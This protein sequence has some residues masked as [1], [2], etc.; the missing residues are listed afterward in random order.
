VGLGFQQAG[1]LGLMISYFTGQFITLGLVIRAVRGDV[2]WRRLKMPVKRLA[3]VMVRHRRFPI[4]TLPS[5]FISNLTINSPIYAL[6][7]IGAVAEIGL[8][9]RANQLLSMPLTILGGAVGQVYQ[10][11][12][13]EELKKKGNCWAVFKRTFLLLFSIGLIP[14][15]LLFVMAPQLFRVV[16]GPEWE[17]AGEIARILSPMLFLRLICSPL[18]T[19]YYVVGAQR[20]DFWLS[21]CSYALI[22]IVMLGILYVRGSSELIIAGFSACYCLT[23]LAFIIGSAALSR[24]TKSE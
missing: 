24:S 16:L 6:Q 20:G 13:A 14:S 1:G 9:S 3:A 11:Q 19:T 15:L 22:A 18:S 23:Y 17:N 5:N 7:G 12:A 2:D 8:Y 21:V 4:Y 10:R